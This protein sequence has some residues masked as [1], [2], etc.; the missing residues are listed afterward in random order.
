MIKV[1]PSVLILLIATTLNIIECSHVNITLKC[2]VS[3]SES[4]LIDKDGIGVVCNITKGLNYSTLTEVQ[5]LEIN[6]QVELDKIKVLAIKPFELTENLPQKIGEQLKNL[7]KFEVVGSKLKYIRNED[8]KGM[9]NLKVLNLG[10]NKIQNF[11]KDTFDNLTNLE[12]LFLHGNEID[13]LQPQTLNKLTNLREFHVD[14]NQ[15]QRIEDNFFKNNLKIEKI[16]LN[17]NKLVYFKENFTRLEKLEFV[18][19]R[20][21]FHE[22]TACEIMEKKA[23]EKR[24][25]DC[26]REKHEKTSK[27]M[28]NFEDCVKI[29]ISEKDELLKKFNG[30]A[31]VRETK[32]QNAT[33]NLETCVK[34]DFR[35]ITIDMIK[36]VDGCI[37]KKIKGEHEA[38]TAFDKCIDGE[39]SKDKEWTQ[40]ITNCST[41]RTIENNAIMSGY[42]NCMYCKIMDEPDNVRKCELRYVKDYNDDLGAFIENVKKFF[43]VK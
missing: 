27:K 13:Y 24:F 3:S 40:L 39:I 29:K 6:K 4:Y 17:E 32:L 21:N 33:K 22:C 23:S 43:G 20:R 34:M 16:S 41:N 38:S 26:E 35:P 9:T 25:N 31:T 7:E 2:Q 37:F 5:G 12:V 42:S 11:K 36:A 19:L 30:C 14:M 1:P 18:D 15:V 28:K 8:F 10:G